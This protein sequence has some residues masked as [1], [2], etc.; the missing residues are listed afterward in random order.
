MG[1]NCV[2]PIVCQHHLMG[3]SEAV[4]KH[5]DWIIL[6]KNERIKWRYPAAWRMDQWE[7]AIRS[8]W[9]GWE[10]QLQ[11]CLNAIGCMQRRGVTF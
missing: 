9:M 4:D 3:E 5:C 2:G 1:R 6:S 8:K 11:A 7:G 10:K